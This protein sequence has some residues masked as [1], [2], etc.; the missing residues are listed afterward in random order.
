MLHLIIFAS[1]R[2][3]GAGSHQG[4]TGVCTTHATSAGVDDISRWLT[5][6]YLAN[7]PERTTFTFAIA[8]RSKDKLGL[9]DL[10]LFE[11]IVDVH[12]DQ[13]VARTSFDVINTKLSQ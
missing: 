5:A 10:P 2:K 11:F 6:I 12:K 8:G 3:T 1:L 9:P 4:T 13:V 7:H